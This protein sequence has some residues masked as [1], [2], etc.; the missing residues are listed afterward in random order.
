MIY[1]SYDNVMNGLNTGINMSLIAP[2]AAVANELFTRVC[3]LWF[4][5]G[6]CAAKKADRSL[7]YGYPTGKAISIRVR[8]IDRL[9]RDGSWRGFRGVFLLHPE[10]ED[11]F[12]TN[13][14]S[15]LIMELNQHNMRYL[16]QWQS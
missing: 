10:I 16:K 2:T 14:R 12:L 3:D 9:D 4:V 5:K 6:Y 13:A 11:E 8:T 1:I 7:K 15:T